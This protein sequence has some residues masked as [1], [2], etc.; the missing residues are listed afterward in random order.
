M[1]FAQLTEHVP[2]A[3]SVPPLITQRMFAPAPLLLPLLLP[4]DEPLLLP[5]LL[6]DDEPLLLPDDEPLLLP[7]LLPVAVGAGGVLLF[8]SPFA[9]PYLP[10]SGG[11]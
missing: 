5:L 4:D 2:L 6:P 1:S 7:L 8:P 3:T 9:G 11:V 10:T